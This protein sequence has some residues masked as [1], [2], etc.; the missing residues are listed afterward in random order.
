MREKWTGDYA[1]ET[2]RIACDNITE[3]F[4]RVTKKSAPRQKKEVTIFEEGGCYYLQ[5]GDKVKQLTTYYVVAVE[6]VVSDEETQYICDFVT[7]K[8]TYRLIMLAEDFSNLDKFKRK[9]T[10]T[11][12]ALGY[13]GTS[14]DLE[15][16]K[17]FIQ[18]LDWKE[19]IGVKTLGIYNHDNALT[20]VSLSGAVKERN[21]PVDN[22]IQMHKHSIID[23]SI[24]EKGFL[25]SKLLKEL[26]THIL[27][28]NEYPKTVSILAWVAGC[29]IKY[30][31]KESETKY[32]H[33]VMIGVAG[34]GKS[35]TMERVICAIFSR[36]VILASS[37]ATS[38][39]LMLE[40]CSSN[41]I[42]Q[43]IN[44][45][46]P[47][48]LPRKVLKAII[49]H[50]RDSYDKHEG[51][52]GKGDLTLNRYELLAPVLVCGEQNPAEAAVRERTIELLFSRSDIEKGD[53]EAAYNW[54][55]ANKPLL[56][57]FGRT[58]LDVALRTTP[59]KA[60][61]WYK[62][63]YEQVKGIFP[64]RVTTN[65]S[66]TYAGLKLVEKMCSFLKLSWTEV[67]PI[68]FD[69]CVKHLMY[70]VR[71]YL[72][73][74]S[75]HS[76]TV[77]EETFEIMAR[78]NLKYEKDYTIENSGKHLCLRLKA[79][80]DDFTQYRVNHAILGEVLTYN[81]FKQQL[82]KS[83]YVINP[84]NP[85]ELRYYNGKRVRVWVLNYEKLQS[86]C[87]VE[88]FWDNSSEPSTK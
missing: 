78:M 36:Y 80:Y 34:S 48:T 88:D 67:F 25:N 50:I 59:E 82:K 62:E 60:N 77:I 19:K 41:L 61:A 6:M 4:T 14:G 27:T 5:R 45:F 70:A 53:Y 39:G 74:G 12:L 79:V 2:V 18:D 9:T 38:F 24:I 15:Y 37:Q 56:E 81:D 72:L 76:R 8:K 35:W 28:Y 13:L 64:N 69:M 32:P 47:S 44:E 85:T 42:P 43:L 73:D 26:G 55:S 46:K 49:N 86:V 17:T 20:F 83:G 30:H 3:G 7:P 29:F 54:I 22:I 87:D 40:S 58:L 66:C 33:F 23:S 16:F 57:D 65:L 21:I 51:M 1:A 10:K 52:R 75:N 11:T 31:L 71:E 63:G 68:D 84:D